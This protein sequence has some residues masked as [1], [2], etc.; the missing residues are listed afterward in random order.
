MIV[1]RQPFYFSEA[2]MELK[3]KK[4]NFLGDSITEGVGTSAPEHI[5]INVIKNM[6][7]LAE[8]RN[9]GISGTRIARQ[10]F[11]NP[12]D[13]F[14]NDFMLRA[15]KMDA[16]ADAVVVFGG[17]NDYGHGQAHL[18]SFDDREPFTF[19]GA[20]HT[21]ITLLI[22]RYM[23]KPIIFMTPLH[24][25]GEEAENSWKPEGVEKHPLCDYVKA[26]REVC[27]Y[28]S[29]PVLDLYR[30]S[31]MST[32]FKPYCDKFMPDGLHPNDNGHIIIANKLASFL[33]N[34]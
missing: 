13:P 8:V 29:V 7:W 28:Y 31:T 34:L 4:I 33:K 9:Y 3:G 19:Y 32:R 22:D 14:D 26:I 16:D 20:L 11:M 12:S 15:P 30:E 10:T 2:I 17:T 24:R 5:Y 27:E 1:E 21:L 25:I 23:G 6:C 18:G